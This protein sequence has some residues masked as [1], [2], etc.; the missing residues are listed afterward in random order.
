VT[1]LGLG[2]TSGKT[3]LSADVTAKKIRKS[4]GVIVPG[5]IN[6]IAFKEHKI[7]MSQDLQKMLTYKTISVDLCT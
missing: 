5:G 3:Y 1:Q 7:A 4:T 2:K 6:R